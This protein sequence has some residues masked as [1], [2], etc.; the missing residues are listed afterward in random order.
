MLTEFLL[1]AL[2][3]GTL[4]AGIIFALISQQKTIN[5]KHDPNAPK[6]TLAADG[7]PHGKPADV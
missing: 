6:S 3:F 4:L 5:R 7:D 1:P 2:A